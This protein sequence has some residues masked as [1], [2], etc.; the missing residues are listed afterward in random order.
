[1]IVVLNNTKTKAKEVKEK[2]IAADETKMSI[3]EKREQFRPVATRGSV[4]YFSI[5]EIS[6]ANPMYQISLDQFLA[7]F[8]QSMDEAEKSTLASKRVANIQDTMTYTTFRYVNRGLYETDKLTFLMILTMKVLVTAELL[9]AR[10]VSLFLRGGASL[11]INSV[12]KKPNSLNWLSNESWLNVLE[13]ASSCQFFSTLPSVMCSNVELWRKW[14]EDNQPEKLPVPEYD[15]RLQEHSEVGPFYKLLLLRAIRLDRTILTAKEF[16]RNTPQM[17]VRYVEPVTDTIDGIYSEMLAEIPVIFLLSVGADPTD[18]IEQLARKKKCGVPAV[19]S[20]GEGQEVIAIKAMSAGATNGAWVLL[21][22]CEL[23]LGLMNDMEEFLANLRPSM[24]SGF[25]LFL[26]ALPSQEFPL[27]LLQMCTKVTNEPPAGLQAG[28]LRSYT[29]MVDQDRLE[30]VDTQ[31]WR[32]LLFNLCFLHSIVQERR[33]FGP[34]G[35]CIPYE[36]NTGDLSAC[37]QFLEKHLYSGQISW[38]TL[39]YMVSEVQYG[40]KITDDF[41][42]RMFMMYA[43]AWLNPDVCEAEFSYNPEAP[44]YSI[45]DSFV[46]VIPDSTEIS[47]YRQV[48]KMHLE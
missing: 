30:R 7:L 38:P 31:Q 29:V 14:Y 27:G 48:S 4:L 15:R 3:N 26:T 19:V 28:L 35:W 9:E 1:M 11:D 20:L 17:G 13:L 10:H 42:R 25:R 22:N 39:Q 43:Q 24:H 6:L 16:V 2:L 37:I 5:V 44:I 21:Q 41:D 32:Q 18:S 45:P 8:I 12:K 33:K 36:Y 47:D 40:G 23:G 34:L 46:Y